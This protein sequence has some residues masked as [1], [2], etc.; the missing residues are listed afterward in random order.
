[1]SMKRALMVLGLVAG[2]VCG[3]VK[4]EMAGLQVTA[5]GY[6]SEG[7]NEFNSLRA[8][9][10][11]L[12]TKVGLLVTSSDKTIVKLDEEKSKVIVFS[13]DQETDLIK[14]KGRF[15]KKS[16]V[17][18]MTSKAKDGKA[19]ITHVESS[20][21]PKKGTKTLT[22]K[23]GLVVSLASK[24]KEVRSELTVLKKGEKL[25]VGEDAFEVNSLRKPD[26]GDDPIQVEL[27]SS[28]SYKDFKGL[29]FYDTKG[30]KIESER[31]GSGSMGIF[32]KRTYTV[33][34]NLKKKVDKI[35]L[36]VDEWS[37]L[38]V[39]KVPFNF[40]IGAGL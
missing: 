18:R 20:G 5:K 38:E 31:S 34:F 26:W 1:M 3:E 23:G 8:F 17:F 11:Q 2:T 35:V 40:T 10:R 9:N 7:E 15:G 12:G 13:D 27:K 37:D 4:V 14:V 33:S 29:H 32:G 21:V 25:V 24:S 30:N 16:G 22:L 6:V 28:V 19:V 39:V 36:A